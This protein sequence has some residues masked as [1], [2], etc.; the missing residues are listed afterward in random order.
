MRL[1]SAIIFREYVKTHSLR[2]TEERPE[3]AA[4]FIS[5]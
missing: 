5:S 3:R 1:A 2:D 4:K